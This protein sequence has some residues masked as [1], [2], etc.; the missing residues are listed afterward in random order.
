METE[1]AGHVVAAL[2]AKLCQYVKLIVQSGGRSSSGRAMAQPLVGLPCPQYVL[3][4]CLIGGEYRP[5]W[6]SGP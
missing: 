3:A 6:P 4:A 1:E 2:S 5:Y